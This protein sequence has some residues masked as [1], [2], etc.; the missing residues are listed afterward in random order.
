MLFYSQDLEE[1]V[2]DL[3]R[4]NQELE[5]MNGIL[6]GEKEEMMGNYKEELELFHKMKKIW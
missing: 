5:E 4:K 1:K 3:M 6:I 2:V